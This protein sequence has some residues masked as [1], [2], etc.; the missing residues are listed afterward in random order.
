[1]KPVMKML[2][3]KI[4]EC[5]V[6]MD[7]GSRI[8]LRTGIFLITLMYFA[9]VLMLAGYAHYFPDYDTALCCVGTLLESA[10]EISGAVIVPVLL[11]ETFGK[12]IACRKG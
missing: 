9:G 5:F 3:Q 1:M 4:N 8:I 11:Y 7:R 10:K 2:L 6:S 12:M